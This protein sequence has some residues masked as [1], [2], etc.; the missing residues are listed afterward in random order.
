M[1]VDDVPGSLSER[2]VL[3]ASDETWALARRRAE[4]IA[5]LAAR[6]PVGHEAADVA[7]AEL[8]LSRRQIYTL[9]SRWCD[10]GG[11]VSDLLPGRSSGGRGRGR[12]PDAVETIVQDG[13]RA[14]YLTR[15]RR[16]VASVHR[17]IVAACRLRG[18]PAPSRGTVRRRIAQLDPLASTLARQG[19]E[20]ARS[21]RS[22]GGS[23][24]TPSAL[25]EQVQIDHT[26]IDLVVVDERERA[27]IGRPYLT[28]GIDMASRT[29]VGMVVTFDAPSATSVGLCLAHMAS[30]KRV[31]LEQ[32]GAQTTWPMVGKPA[33]LYVDNGAEFHSEA[34]R[35][36]CEE[37]GIAL[38]YRPGDQPH[39]GGIVERLIGTL[40][41][42]VHELPG[43][44]FSNSAERGAYDSGA[45]AALTLTELQRWLALAVTAYHGRVHETL[46]RPPGAVWAEK[47]AVNP[48]AAVTNAT[49]F[50]IDFLPVIRRR[51]TRTGLVIDHVHYYSDALKPLIARRDQ[52]ERLVV[53]R[54]PR[55][56]SRVWVLDPDSSAYLMVGYRNLA[57]PAISLWEHRA[58]MTRL[59]ET[60]RGEVDEQALFATVTA[61][62]EVSDTAVRTTRRARR[63]RA[64]RPAPP[65]TEISTVAGARMG[66]PVADEAADTEP[67]VAFA[68]IEQW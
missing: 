29:V 34:L 24:P 63:A 26:V 66:A 55:D 62:R 30:D 52:L 47:A 50:L 15:Q 18:L 38:G 2:G 57:R 42:E 22:A 9:V 33:A 25:L 5:P 31:W 37:H 17:S 48:P 41:Q 59:R 19:V 12:V 13:L 64:H 43:T 36:G 23:A 11:V 65:A 21:L 40:M 68:D 44:T 35:R 20:A 6:G 45:R 60:G 10:G 61:M 28:V 27:P 14:G 49:A 39:Y 51:L 8:G 32:V 67:A 46:S 54:D 1:S 3:T 16:S 56:L 7:A 4:V 58:A 53:R